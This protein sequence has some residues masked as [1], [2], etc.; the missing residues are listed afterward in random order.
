MNEAAAQHT[1]RPPVP[2]VFAA[3]GIA[4]IT[5][6]IYWSALGAGF[7]GDD[8][9]ILH[10]LR[11][12]SGPA[13]ALGFFRGE[14][15]EY[16]R[17]LGFVSHALDWAIAGQ[18]ARQF[19]LTNLLIHSFNAVVVLLIGRAL[20]PRSLAGPLAALLFALHA[21]NTEPVIWMSARFDLLAT[22][23]G[24]S[25][26]CWLIRG[27]KGSPW[28]LSSFCRRCFRRRPWWHYLWARQV[29]RRSAGAR[30]LEKRS[31]PWRPGWRSSPSIVLCVTLPAA[32]PRSEVR[33]E[34]RSWQL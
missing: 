30:P 14:F 5:I 4:A 29:G 8:F 17:P 34:F 6:A 19:H 7:V 16:Y 32:S 9:M 3:A 22:C 24:L 10:R 27:W 33:H 1:N 13:D 21:S 20:S 31:S 23:F 11:A 15:F 28:L 2:A 12:L 25:A 18:N 26:L